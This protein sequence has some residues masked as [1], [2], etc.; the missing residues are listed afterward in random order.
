[1]HSLYKYTSLIALMTFFVSGCSKHTPSDSTASDSTSKPLVEYL[2]KDT[3]NI[4]WLMLRPTGAIVLF[5]EPCGVQQKYFKAKIF[6]YENGKS[7]PSTEHTGCYND[8]DRE[9]GPDGKIKIVE[10]DGTTIGKLI[11]EIPFSELF[12]PKDYFLPLDNDPRN[13]PPK[14]EALGV[15]SNKLE[16]GSYYETIGLTRQACPF[17]SKLLLARHIPVASADGYEKCWQENGQT[18]IVHDVD[19]S[20][21][22]PRLSADGTN[23]DKNSFFSASTVKNTPL[24][25]EW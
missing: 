13:S 21:A 17:D 11:V 2:S 4:K 14:I 18:I 5:N 7:A 12:D 6:V 23:I 9:F 16:S 19:Y 1:M 3:A 25:Y 10:S 20:G 22:T 8:E 24:K 15:I